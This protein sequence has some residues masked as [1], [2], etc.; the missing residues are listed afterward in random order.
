MHS[1]K[2]LS[3]TLTYLVSFGSFVALHSLAYGIYILLF[4][5]ITAIGFLN[6]LKFGHYPPRWILTVSGFLLSIFFMLDLSFD[7]LIAPFANIL[8]LLIA[9]KSLEE[10]KPRDI[11][12]M[13]LLSLFGVALS[14][15]FRFDL[16][17]LAFFLYELFLGSIAFLFTN[18]YSNA[19]DLKLSRTFISRYTRFTVIY[20]VLVFLLSLPFFIALPRTY[21]PLFDFLASR[22]KT[23][24][25]GIAQ[26]V[27]LGKVGE[28]QQDNTVVMRVYGNLPEVAYW[29]VAVFET[30]TG[31]KW[32]RGRERGSPSPE[33]DESSESFRYRVILTPTYDNFIPLLDFP[34]SIVKIEGYR[35]RVRRV[36]GGYF[37][38]T[39]PVNKPIRYEAV[40]VL[41][42]PTDP[43]SGRLLSLPRDIPRSVKELADRLQM[44]APSDEEKVQKVIAY[45][46]EGFRYTLRLEQYEGHPLE[47][48]L[49]RSK[50]G[51]CEF[52][53]SST[54]VLL[55]LMGIPA[56]LVGGFKGY[57][58]NDFGNY[59]I[60]TNSMA[61]VWVEAYVN[62]RWMRIDTTPPY[63]SPAVREISKID[64][65]RDA[66]V[67]FWFE[68]VVD[69]SLSK[70][71]S[72]LRKARVGFLSLKGFDI[73]H[74]L[75][76]LLVVATSVFL[77]AVFLY[78][79]LFHIRRTP[80]NLY[81]KL[82]RRLEKKFGMDLSGMLPEEVLKS[83]EG[84]EVYGKAEFIVR[85]YQKE[86]FSREKVS[87]EEIREGYRV[88][89]NIY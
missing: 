36:E 68:N 79:F 56:R 21:T 76:E 66:I 59:Y 43:P 65:I 27:E 32:I 22:E 72:L 75:K 20:P 44:G 67:S 87:R 49:F 55:R 50:A 16:S 88:L 70:Q 81:R 84:T 11:Y 7:D 30:M 52:F 12:Q 85:L 73:K 35:G 77:A 60:V 6:D 53:A 23:L 18:L 19:G 37:T 57:I 26:D 3:L 5:L 17:F 69:Y 54:A 48:F 71:R 64:L 2:S 89:R 82:L 58:R 45:F 63:R 42:M 78:L 74:V 1:A 9:I 41:A 34:K 61:H 83:L 86:R 80:K 25:S 15:T 13:L 4:S 40:S 28:I 39:R 33:L 38:G 10:K 31:T 29:R 62:G 46:K 47:H 8:L 14:A 24:S 51:N